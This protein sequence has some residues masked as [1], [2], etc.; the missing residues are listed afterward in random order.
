MN[1]VKLLA[2][3]SLRR[4]PEL[5]QSEASECGLA[6]LAMIASYHGMQVDMPILRRKFSVGMRGA[7]LKNLIDISGELGFDARP[8]RLEVR[9]LCDLEAPCILHW[10]LSHFVVLVGVKKT[11]KGYR[12]HIK[13]PAKGTLTLGEK[14]ASQLFTGVAL[15]LRRTTRFYPQIA[16]SKLKISQL[17]SSINGA[18]STLTGVLFLSAILQLITLTSPFYL[19]IVVDTI[20]P[21]SDNELLY[22]LAVGF[23]GLAIINALTSQLRS[24]SLIN[25]TYAFSFQIT[26]N[27]YKHLLSLPLSWFEKRHVGDIISRFNSTQPI[28]DVFSQGV[29]SAVIDG[30]MAFA[31]LTLMLFYSPMLASMA[32]A[33]WIISI[34][35]KF[36]SFR[37]ISHANL[38]VIAA[39]ARESSAFIET[40]RGI[41]SIKSSGR[42]ATR[43]KTWQL[44]KVNAINAQLKLGRITTN[45][46]TLS[47]LAV[48][49]EQ[50]IF[51]YLA[52]RLAISG[53]FTIGMIFAFQAYKQQFLGA[54][55]R[56]ADQAVRYRLVDVHLSRIADIALSPAEIGGNGV[57][58]G[59]V[60]GGEIELRDVSF[61]YSTGE[62][63]IISNVNLKIQRGQMVAFVGP[64]GAG[65]TTLLKIMMGLLEPTNGVVLIDGQ[66]LTKI[67]LRNWRSK[68]GS[69]LQEDQL[70]AGSLAENIAFFDDEYDESR[71]HEVCREAAILTE[72]QSLP[73]QFDTLV[74]DMGSSLSGG[75]KQRV[76]LARALYSRP[77][78]LFMDE[79]TANLDP[80]TEERVVEALKN[81]R[82][83]RVINAHRPLAVNPASRVFL[84]Q[85]GSVTV[86]R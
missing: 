6:C 65:K 33:A 18:T 47:S 45:F 68:I 48:A 25:M 67:G 52:A 56:L 23:G 2:F 13:D 17:W 15:E 57:D 20:L 61:R 83:T 55:T 11:L 27:I 1:A 31:T 29:I 86:L 39:S 26:N 50:V 5:R 44:L 75:Q 84:V 66:P 19:Q 76:L 70:F 58:S 8:L 7:T 51:V 63:E 53:G 22:V 64:S 73:L 34:A 12:Y 78:V 71:I 14:E 21:S 77:A 38:N 49:L 3:E 62:P 35:I 28:T 36:F 81:M 37:V 43:Q 16:K 24:I 80:A 82:I 42:E 9:E 10:S 60:T 74:G 41:A 4:V 69:V 40:I 59:K 54:S 32:L 79:G 30:A 72:I 46:D 85:S